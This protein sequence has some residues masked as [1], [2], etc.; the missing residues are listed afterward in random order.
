M[1]TALFKA[2]FAILAGLAKALLTEAVLKKLIV[3]LG[4]YLIPKSSNR[5]DDELWKPV[6]DALLD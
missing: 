2:L 3:A 4:D 1:K 6:R 5:L